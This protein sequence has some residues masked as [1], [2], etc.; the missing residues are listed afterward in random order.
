MRVY[1]K[2]IPP[3]GMAWR[4]V[5][6]L[7]GRK[8]ERNLAPELDNTSRSGTSDLPEIIVRVRSEVGKAPIHRTLSRS[9]GCLR[10]WVYSI[11]R[12]VKGIERLDPKLETDALRELERLRQSDIPVVDTGLRQE[13]AG[14]VPVSTE[15]GPGKGGR[16]KPLANTLVADTWTT[17]QIGSLAEAG[18]CEARAWSCARQR[19]P[20][21]KSNNGS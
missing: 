2:K 16:V 15:S 8:L 21:L 9:A 6:S 11:L 12:V 14:P 18:L 7:W 17:D 4:V 5:R 19:E 3:T 13:V 1:L 20:P 10:C